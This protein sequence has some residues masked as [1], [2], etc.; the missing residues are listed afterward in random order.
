MH[1]PQSRPPDRHPPARPARPLRLLDVLAKTLSGGD[2]HLRCLPEARTPDGRTMQRLSRTMASRGEPDADPARQA[3]PGLMRCTS[4]AMRFV[5]RK[6]SPTRNLFLTRYH[7]WGRLDKALTFPG[8]TAGVNR[9]CDLAEG[10]TRNYGIFT[11]QDARQM[12]R[13]GRFS[14]VGTK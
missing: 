14:D 4:I 1:G 5:I 12:V 8:S 3:V 11:L 7:R 2:P 6:G 10:F 9:A 13:G